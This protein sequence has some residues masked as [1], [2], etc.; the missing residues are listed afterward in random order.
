MSVGYTWVQWSHHKRVY[1][2][3]M[4]AG[5]ALYLAVFVVLSKYLWRGQSSIS[6]EVL[7]IRATG[8]CAIVMLHVIL[9]LGP[10]ARLNARFLPLMY[11]RRHLGVMTFLIALVHA[12]VV[13]GYYHG[14]GVL[15]PLVSLL[16][17]NT[18]YMSVSAFPFQVLGLGA[19]LILFLLAAT[20][21]DFWLRNLSPSVWKSLHMLV[22]AAY[23][24][25]VGH[26]AFGALQ[27]DRGLIGPMAM[28][29]GVCLV[30]GLHLATGR[31][32]SRRDRGSAVSREHGGEWISAGP[33]MSIPTDRARVVC[34]PG[35]ERIAVFRY[36]DTI[37]AVTNVCAHQGGPLG[38]G[39]VVDGCITCPWHG[40]Q[41]LPGD[42]C[43][44]PPFSEKIATYQVRVVRGEVMVSAR[45]MPPGTALEPASC[46]VIT[47][48]PGNAKGVAG[49]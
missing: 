5:A 34:V 17:T 48:A 49:A 12:V 13:L 33:A 7:L 41:Y 20:S 42:G 44:P 15:N 29:V 25:L 37:S 31:R 47:D 4:A 10:L 8:S 46:R 14:F 43:S 26:V 28:G 21:H 22:Y 35:G 3:V 38:E 45:A 6:D 2:G 11:N 36:Q 32:E 40:W 19:L 16:T 39:K 24:L 9:C 30:G 18:N 27:A 1:D 23:A